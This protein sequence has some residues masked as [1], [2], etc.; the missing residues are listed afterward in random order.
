MDTSCCTAC[1]P[2]IELLSLDL[3]AFFGVFTLEAWC[4]NKFDSTC[5]E[6]IKK[7]RQQHQHGMNAAEAQTFVDS[8]AEAASLPT[9]QEQK[10][11][12]EALFGAPFFGTFKFV[13]NPIHWSVIQAISNMELPSHP[14]W[15]T[16]D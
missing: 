11:K 15:A 4:C 7:S 9:Q 12:F 3:Q 8:V 6:A 5:P 14:I 16:M 10:S 13:Q 1:R 2:L